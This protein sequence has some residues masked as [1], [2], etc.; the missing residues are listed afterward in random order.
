[1]RSRWRYAFPQQIAF[2]LV[3]AASGLRPTFAVSS[4]DWK[5]PLASPLVIVLS[6]LARAEVAERAFASGAR[7]VLRKPT[8]TYDLLLTVE[9]AL[10]ESSPLEVA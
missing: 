8:D 10:A 9:A 4:S 1:M 5:E 7:Y 3:A 2:V 6:G